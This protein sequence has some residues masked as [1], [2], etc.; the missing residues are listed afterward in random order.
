MNNSIITIE[1]IA[2]IK[3]QYPLRWHGTHGI[4]HWN[5]VYQNGVKL[6]SQKGVNAKI[7][8]LFSV[9]HDSQ[10]LNE[11]KDLNHGQRGA[12]LAGKLREYLPLNDD[13]LDLLV[14][15]CSLH[16]STLDHENITV[17]V[18][19]DSDRLDLGRVGHI[20]DPDRLCTPMAKMDK[21]IQWAYHRSLNDNGLPEIP[22]GLS[23]T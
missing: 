2:Q 8:E 20:P 21:T 9:F 1:L 14:T 16:T 17:Q 22:F 3:K 12:E 4:L 6:A 23:Q 5:R 13:E 15:A 19:M 11:G 7:V 10:R 18:C